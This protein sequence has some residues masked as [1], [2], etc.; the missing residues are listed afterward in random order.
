MSYWSNY[1]KDSVRLHKIRHS[2]LSFSPVSVYACASCGEQDVVLRLCGNCRSAVYCNVDCQRADWSSH[3][4]FCKLRNPAY[5]DKTQGSR[6]QWYTDLIKENRPE[7]PEEQDD[8]VLVFLIDSFCVRC[9]DE[10]VREKR[11]DP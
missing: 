8:R 9:L 6:I 4:K 11:M 10:A 1:N 5:F 7:T 3:R 2:I